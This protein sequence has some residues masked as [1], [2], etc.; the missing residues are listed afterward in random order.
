MSTESPKLTPEELEDHLLPIALQKLQEGN[1]DTT[2]DDIVLMKRLIAQQ[3]PILS[4]HMQK[5]ILSTP[6]RAAFTQRTECN[7]PTTDTSS[8]SGSLQSPILIPALTQTRFEFKPSGP[9][10]IKLERKQEKTWAGGSLPELFP[11][12]LSEAMQ[13]IRDSNLHVPELLDVLENYDSKYSTLTKDCRNIND[14]IQVLEN[15][16]SFRDYPILKSIATKTND[17]HLLQRISRY[18]FLHQEV[19]PVKKQEKKPYQKASLKSLIGAKLRDTKLRDTTVLR[20]ELRGVDILQEVE[21]YATDSPQLF[22]WKGYGLRLNIP[23]GS[24]PRHVR[25]CTITIRASLSGQYHFPHNTHL[26]SPVFWLQCEPDCKFRFPLS[27]EI[28]HCAPLENSFRLFMVKAQC[29]Q[30]DLPYLFKTL[31]GGTFTETSSYGSI[32]MDLFSGIGVVQERSDEHRYWSNVFYMGPPN[33]SNIHFTVTWHTDAH[34]TVS[35]R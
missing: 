17:L 30:K 26:V 33:N 29:T 6:S 25:C 9:K 12:L 18:S 35:G 27:L 4:E 24:L 8:P 13:S 20:A 5:R 10:R 11:F 16:I 1:G 14:I 21:V 31:H 23:P 2:A 15:N 28:Q 19:V 32:A 34:I 3:Y 7:V 22:E